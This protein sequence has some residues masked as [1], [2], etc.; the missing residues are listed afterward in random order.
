[1]WIKRAIATATPTSIPGRTEIIIH[2]INRIQIGL[3]IRLANLAIR[4]KVGHLIMET[5]LEGIPTMGPRIR[6]LATPEVRFL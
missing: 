6:E 5:V 4:D 2:P 3:L 1:M